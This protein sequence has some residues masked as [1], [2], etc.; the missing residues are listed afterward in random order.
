MSYSNR[1]IS[2][3]PD[4]MKAV[5]VGSVTSGGVTYTGHYFFV[6]NNTINEYVYKRF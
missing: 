3:T 6:F 5:I 4:G 1:I 2:M